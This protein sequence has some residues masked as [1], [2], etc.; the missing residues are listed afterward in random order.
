[1]N[2]L[3]TLFGFLGIGSTLPPKP[4]R[5]CSPATLS[6]DDFAVLALVLVVLG[7]AFPLTD[8]LFSLAALT[9]LRGVGG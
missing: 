4:S 5:F 2:A 7:L 9:L 6:K 8:W 3:V 1:M